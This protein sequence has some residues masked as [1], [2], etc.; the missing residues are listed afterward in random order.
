VVVGFHVDRFALLWMPILI[1]VASNQG[2]CLAGIAIAIG[3]FAPTLAS[4][5]LSGAS[6]FGA[7]LV[8][9]LWGSREAVHRLASS[10]PSKLALDQSK[11]KSPPEE[12]PPAIVRESNEEQGGNENA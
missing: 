7:L 6:L 9:V 12:S 3:A 4:Q 10:S 2:G 1:P 11:A 5:L 8:L